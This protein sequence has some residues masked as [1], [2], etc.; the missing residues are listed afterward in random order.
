M[1]WSSKT[2]KCVHVAAGIVAVGVF[3]AVQVPAVANPDIDGRFDPNEGYDIGYHVDVDI[4]GGGTVTGGQAWFKVDA[5]GDLHMALIMPTTVIDNSYGVNAI[6][7]P[8]GNHRFTHLLNSDDARFLFKDTYG[9]VVVDVGLDY[10]FETSSTVSGYDSGLAFDNE[11]LSAYGGTV[12]LGGASVLDTATSLGYNFN[13]L[14]YVLTV[15]SP[16]ADDNYNNVDPSYEDWIFDIIYEMKIDGDVFGAGGF[17]DPKA[18]VFTEL[19]H[20]SPNKLGGSKTWPRLDG[21]ITQ[22]P[23]GVIPEPLTMLGLTAGVCGLGGYLRKRS[24]TKVG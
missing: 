18:Q 3:L 4:E 16:A 6:G 20:L 12:A 15:D 17:V 21:L 19:I 2:R 14:G 8:G 9:N 22:P 24:R 11:N 7:W 1:V 23:N 10:L 5:Q 13:D